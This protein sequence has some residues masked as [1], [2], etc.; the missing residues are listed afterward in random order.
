MLKFS[1]GEVVWLKE[2]GEYQQITKIWVDGTGKE[3][4][5]EFIIGAERDC[6][7][8]RDLRRLNRKERG[9]R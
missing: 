5:Y 2:R 8:E 1:R 3:H 9:S 6:Q 4:V 7:N